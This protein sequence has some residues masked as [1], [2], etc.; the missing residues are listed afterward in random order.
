[1]PARRSPKKISGRLPRSKRT[2]PRRARPAASGPPPER[3]PSLAALSKRI[4]ELRTAAH[5]TQEELAS[6]AGISVAFASMLERAARSAS[7]GTL[8]RVARALGVPLAELFRSGSDMTY[9]DPY[10]ERLIDFAAAAQLNHGDVERLLEVACAMF[11]IPREKI[12]PQPVPSPA[13][14]VALCSIKDCDR[15]ALAKGLCAS[16]Y[17]AQRRE[18]RT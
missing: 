12:P 13:A 5:I 6:R 4:R 16:H 10:F 3:D 8:V 11:Q 18:Q 15:P 2:P 1:M 14:P 9:D 17:H 7:I